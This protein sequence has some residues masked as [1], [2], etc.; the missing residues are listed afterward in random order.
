MTKLQVS[1]HSEVCP[2]ISRSWWGWERPELLVVN[3]KV[4]FP[5]RLCMYSK[6]CFLWQQFYKPNNVTSWRQQ[7][8]QSLSTPSYNKI[9]QIQRCGIH[10]YMKALWNWQRNSTL[11]RARHDGKQRHHKHFPADTPCKHWKSYG[12]VPTIH[13]S[14]AAGNEHTNVSGWSSFSSSHRNNGCI[15]HQKE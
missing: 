3:P 14:L 5:Q 11:N 10:D 15:W 9:G 2:R 7:R 4:W 13:G 12:E 6:V 8:K 1:F